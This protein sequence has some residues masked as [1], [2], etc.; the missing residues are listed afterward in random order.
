MKHLNLWTLGMCVKAVFWILYHLK[1]QS[2]SVVSGGNNSFF[3]FGQIFER[4]LM[5]Q[6]KSCVES[7]DNIQSG[8]AYHRSL[9][10]TI[11]AAQ[12]ATVKVSNSHQHHH[13]LLRKVLSIQKMSI[14]KPTN[15][16][17]FGENK[18]ELKLTRALVLHHGYLVVFA[19]SVDFFNWSVRIQVICH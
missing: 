17:H 1:S 19:L 12:N 18:I 4:D 10:K 15:F 2:C 14:L 11:S 13:S 8:A 6:H 16:S 7:C 3:L 9:L 5:R